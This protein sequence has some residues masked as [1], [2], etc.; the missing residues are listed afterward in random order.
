M[1]KRRFDV[2]GVVSRTS[3][4]FSIAQV[5][6][7]AGV[8]TTFAEAIFTVAEATRLRVL[9]GPPLFQS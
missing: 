9:T 6:T 4:L 7:P 8:E 3:I 2:P 1:V 5:P